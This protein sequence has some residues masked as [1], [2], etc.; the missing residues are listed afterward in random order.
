MDTPD[1]PDEGHD[2]PYRRPF[3]DVLIDLNRGRTAGELTDALA[4][5]ITRVR[6]TGRAGSLHLAI[7]VKPLRGNVDVLEVSDKVVCKAPEYDRKTSI[8][9]SDDT[10]NLTRTDPNQPTL[11][12]LKVVPEHHP[13]QENIK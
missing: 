7:A 8:F 11:S 1:T 4:T 6:E 12:G 13:S 2:D 5:L 3:V 9:Y 10:G